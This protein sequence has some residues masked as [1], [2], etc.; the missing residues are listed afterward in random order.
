MTGV[1]TYTTLEPNIWRFPRWGNN[2]YYPAGS[3]VSVRLDNPFDSEVPIYAYYVSITDVTADNKTDSTGTVIV[4]G[5]S[6]APND[7]DSDWGNHSNYLSNPWVLAFDTTLTS[8]SSQLTS[9]INSLSSLFPL[10][11]I[12]SDLAILQNTDSDL[13]LQIWN[14][15]SDILMTRHDAASWDSDLHYLMMMHLD[16][17][18]HGRKAEDSDLHTRI[19]SEVAILDSDIKMEIHDRKAADSDM[20]W[21]FQTQIWNNDSDILMEIHDREAG[22]SDLWIHVDS[23]ILRLDRI[24][25]SDSD[26]LTN[27][28]HRYYERDS[29]IAVK[30]DEHDSDIDWL[31]I[32]AKTSSGA[33]SN[34]GFPVG[35][36]LMFPTTTMPEGFALCDGSS[37]SA[38]TY[39][40]LA[41]LLGSTNLPDMRGLFVRGWSTNNA[42]DPSGPRAPLSTQADDFKAHTHNI[43]INNGLFSPVIQFADGTF[44]TVNTSGQNVVQ[45]SGGITNVGGLETRPKNIAMAFGIA[46]Y[47][48]AGII[49]D[50]EIIE[51]ILRIRHADMDSDINALYNLNEFHQEIYSPTTD[52]ASGSVHNITVDSSNFT[53]ITVLLNGVEVYQWSNAGT[54]FTLNFALRAN[55]DTVTFKLR[56]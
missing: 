52:Q 6:W 42:N 37:F 44:T 30:F 14:N 5:G 45:Q 12:D 50:S 31:L 17:E 51:Q 54:A 36:I 11:G 40:D 4:D 32:Y 26:R 24:S 38:A 47:N 1:R 29:D 16:S 33:G 56:R 28:I 19:D 15:D 46:M 34:T 53:D 7:S 10:L 39:P 21:D 3:F 25:D 8:L 41:A 2:I 22:D 49:Y 55:I 35:S 27:F 13:Q 48:G 43:N 18:I 9:Q 23:E 20:Y